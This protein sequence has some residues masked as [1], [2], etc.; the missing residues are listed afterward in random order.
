MTVYRYEALICNQFPDLNQP[1]WSSY[2]P[3]KTRNTYAVSATANSLSHILTFT[4]WSAKYPV[5]W[6]SISPLSPQSH[7]E[8][9]HCL[10][11]THLWGWLCESLLKKCWSCHWLSVDWWRTE[12][13]AT[14]KQTLTPTYKQVNKAENGAKTPGGGKRCSGLNWRSLP[15]L[16]QCKCRVATKSKSASSPD[17]NKLTWAP[18]RR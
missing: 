5:S 13:S 14:R 1:N 3:L 2:R 18:T 11:S 4:S 15:G 9:A 7:R 6:S 16:S 10:K 17:G 12:G 8:M